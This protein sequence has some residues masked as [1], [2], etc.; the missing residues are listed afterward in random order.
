MSGEFFLS[1]WEVT[2]ELTHVFRHQALLDELEQRINQCHT[3]GMED[4]E[5]YERASKALGTAGG[6]N[7]GK[8]S[9]TTPAGKDLTVK[10]VNLGV[11]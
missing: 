1:Q 4:E 3:K 7:K 6:A 10:P 5:D 11:H 9:V 2:L 8:K